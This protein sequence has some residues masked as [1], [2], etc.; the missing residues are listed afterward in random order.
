MVTMAT[1]RSQ[2]P[3]PVKGFLINQ[4][5]T[6]TDLARRIGA[7]REHV[8]RALNRREPL[9]RDLALA[10]A[11]D[12]GLGVDEVALLLGPPSTW[13]RGRSRAPGS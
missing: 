4:G 7:S 6:I 3:L 5:L 8:V 9:T 11:V 12:L 10:V 2:R 13:A 1:E